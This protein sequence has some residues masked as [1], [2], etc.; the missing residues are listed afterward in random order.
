[1]NIEHLK[2]IKFKHKHRG[3]DFFGGEFI[4]HSVKKNLEKE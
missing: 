1:M 2:G 4:F 3:N